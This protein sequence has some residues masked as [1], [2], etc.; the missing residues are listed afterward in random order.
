MHSKFLGLLCG[1][2]YVLTQ[3]APASIPA[4]GPP[5]AE[6][7]RKVADTAPFNVTL[8]NYKL[9]SQKGPSPSLSHGYFQTSC[10]S[11]LS[12]HYTDPSLWAGA[13]GSASL[14]VLVLTHGYP[15]S[16]Y[17]WRELTGPLSARVPLFVPDVL[18]R[19]SPAPSRTTTPPT[20]P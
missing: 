5:Q 8:A 20:I 12:F 19:P 17:E 7:P 4:T 11:N 1:Y 3:A 18:L 14:P 10:G 9:P 6:W 16:S 13:A 15:E 2:A